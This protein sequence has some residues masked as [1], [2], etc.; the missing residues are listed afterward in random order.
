MLPGERDLLIASTRI[1]IHSCT[2][3]YVTVCDGV[4]R[5]RLQSVTD[6]HTRI[7][8]GCGGNIG[9]IFCAGCGVD[10]GDDGCTGC[11]VDAGDAGDAGCGECAGD[12]GCGV[13][14]GDAG[15]AGSP[16]CG[17]CAGDVGSARF[18]GW[19]TPITRQKGRSNA[20]PR[21]YKKFGSIYIF[22]Q[23]S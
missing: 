9:Y 21:P 4:R 20:R 8:A 14:A 15:D 17:E 10:A 19:E 18:G 22:T 12:A 2:R 16:R 1:I 11:G 7:Y 3:M 5:T 13:D 23:L 6:R